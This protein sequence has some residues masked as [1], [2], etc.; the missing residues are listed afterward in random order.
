LDGRGRRKVRGD[1][2]GHLGAAPDGRRVLT[3]D[4]QGIGYGLLISEDNAMNLGAGLLFVI[5]AATMVLARKVD[6][7]RAAVWRIAGPARLTK[8]TVTGAANGTRR[9]SGQRGIGGTG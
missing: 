3:S 8:L 6:W 4:R 9:P 1:A 5:L 7:Y 2:P